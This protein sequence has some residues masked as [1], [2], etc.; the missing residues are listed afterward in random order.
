MGDLT[1]H[2]GCHFETGYMN[3]THNLVGQWSWNNRFIYC[4]VDLTNFTNMP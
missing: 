4:F 2:N 3:L 1:W